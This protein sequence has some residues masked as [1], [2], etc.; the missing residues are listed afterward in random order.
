MYLSDVV[1]ELKYVSAIGV[2]DFGCYS[3]V[4]VCLALLFGGVIRVAG[5]CVGFVLGG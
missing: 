4:F 5:V 3:W 1:R 2:S